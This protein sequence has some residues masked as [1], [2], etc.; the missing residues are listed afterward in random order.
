MSNAPRETDKFRSGR[1]VR[2]LESWVV[3]E[4]DYADA[5]RWDRHE[6]SQ[7]TPT[8]RWAVWTIAGEGNETYWMTILPSFFVRLRWV[9]TRASLMT[10]PSSGIAK[11]MLVLCLDGLHKGKAGRHY[12]LQLSTLQS[13]IPQPA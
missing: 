2:I 1:A 4:L 12:S 9:V 8:A 6:P 5:G 3:F 13:S 10:L 11:K 7:G